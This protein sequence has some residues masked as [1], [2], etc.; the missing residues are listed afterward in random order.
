MKQG[1]KHWL[2]SSLLGGASAAHKLTK[3]FSSH[4]SMVTQVYG[5]VSSEPETVM[6]AKSLFWGGFWSKAVHPDSLQSVIGEV[7][8]EC[9]ST[10]GFEAIDV[11]RF[12]AVACLWQ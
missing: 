10:G 9:M 1:F 7:R 2:A 11:E 6:R 8:R 3:V 12:R 5:G 4:V